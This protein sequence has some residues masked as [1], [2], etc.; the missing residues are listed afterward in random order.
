MF[1]SVTEDDLGRRERKKRETRAALAGAALRLASEKGPDAVTVE[2]IAEA[3]DVS[4]RTFFNYFA[5]KEAAIL[6]ADPDPRSV[7]AERLLA[8]P[9]EEPPL[10]ALRRVFVDTFGKASD[11]WADQRLA[12]QQLVHRHPSLLPRHLA[13]HHDL[14]LQLR[15]ALEERLGVERDA[16]VYPA[17]VVGAAVVA[18]RL[19]LTSWEAGGR[20]T[21]IAY[22]LEAAFDAIERGLVPPEEM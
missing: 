9:A 11:E 16:S 12:R 21:S 19:C 10:V 8:R 4:L 7:L 18:M 15:R 20:A 3:A 13:F 14:E 5:C 2:E 17:L 6:N 1:M 22:L